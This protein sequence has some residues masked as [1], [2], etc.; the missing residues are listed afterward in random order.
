MKTAQTMAESIKRIALINKGSSHKQMFLFS[1][2]NGVKFN[3]DATFLNQ[4]RSS[5]V[6]RVSPGVIRVEANIKR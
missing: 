5:L 4:L 6:L 2:T 1:R 3:D